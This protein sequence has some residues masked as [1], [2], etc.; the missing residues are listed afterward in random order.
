VHDLIPIDFPEYAR[1]DHDRRHM[2]RMETVLRHAEGVIVNSTDTGLSLR[3]FIEKQSVA[4][5][6]RGPIE[7]RTALLGTPS[8]PSLPMVQDLAARPYFVF[9]STIEPRKNHLMLLNLWRS[10][11]A[12][13]ANP[14]GL[15][16]VGRRGWEN[17]NVIDM[18]ERC[19]GLQGLVEEY[20]DLSDLR[21]ASLLSGARALVLPSFAEGYGLPLAEALALGVPALCSDLPSLREIGGEVP[22]YFDP[23]DAVAWRRAILDYAAPDAPRR[24]AQVARI[25][26]WRAP[27][28]DEH[29]ATIETL[30]ADVG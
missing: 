13:E 6:L 21:L 25:G 15:K 9:L 16:L 27:N 22:E 28:W 29:F 8:F 2:K 24:A 18:L 7:I 3:R 20:N 10:L 11:A 17:E 23:L 30:L 26:Q 5:G 19:P 4:S 14:P 12:S 1:P